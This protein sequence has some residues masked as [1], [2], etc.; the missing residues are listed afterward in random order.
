MIQEL[1][2][3]LLNA[4]SS[5]SG[6][7]TAPIGVPAY[8]DWPP[9]PQIPCAVVTYPLTVPPVSGGQFAGS[10]V[11]AADVFLCVPLT[12]PTP[13]QT[14]ETLIERV[15]DNSNDWALSG[16]DP[17]AEGDFKGV[18]V[19]HTRVHLARQSKLE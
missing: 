6:G 10:F 3:A 15:L 5:G 11:V 12:D 8:G 14:L 2:T 1:R 19:L 16:V 13:S 7:T 17:Y 9:R 4:I 18:A